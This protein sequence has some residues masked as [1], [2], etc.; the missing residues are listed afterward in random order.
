MLYT[1]LFRQPGVNSRIEFILDL[2]VFDIYMPLVFKAIRF[3]KLITTYT[4]PFSGIAFL[5][6]LF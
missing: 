3:N 5:S 1:N 4:K 6:D 2:Q